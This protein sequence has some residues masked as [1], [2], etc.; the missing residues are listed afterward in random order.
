GQAF[1]DLLGYRFERGLHDHG[2]DRFVPLFR[3]EVLLW[4][5]YAAQEW[6]AEVQSWPSSLQKMMQLMAAQQRLGAALAAVRRADARA[7]GRRGP[8]GGGVREMGVRGDV[9][10]VEGL[11]LARGLAEGGMGIAG[12]SATGTPAERTRLQAEAASLERAVD[13]VADALTAEGVYHV[14][15]GN[16]SRASASVDALAHGELQPPELEFAATPRPGAAGTHRSIAVSR[17]TPP[18]ARP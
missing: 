3:R 9:G 6:L 1:G 11:E 14:V 16:P 4:S 2:L 10:V 8:D 7:G 15:R 18:P 12:R 13:A 5:V 17:H